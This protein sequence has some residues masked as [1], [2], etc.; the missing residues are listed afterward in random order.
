[1]CFAYGIVG[2]MGEGCPRYLSTLR[3]SI[4]ISRLMFGMLDADEEHALR[5]SRVLGNGS[6]D[7]EFLVTS[8]HHYLLVA[9]FSLSFA[10]GR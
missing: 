2:K 1:M 5:F 7:S 10:R 8:L 6:L 9:S 3:S 4:L